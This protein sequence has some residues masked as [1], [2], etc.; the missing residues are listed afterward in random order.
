MPYKP[1][2]TKCRAWV[3]TTNN[4]DEA[5]EAHL[6]SL[7]S[8]GGA[9]YLCY[10]REVG[11]ECGTPHLQGFVYFENPR[12]FNGVRSTLCEG[13]H[14]EA[15]RG[16][17]EQSI[18]YC[19]KDGDFVELGKRPISKAGSDKAARAVELARAGDLETLESEDPG[20]FL[21]HFRT[22]GALATCSI[23][24]LSTLKNYWLWGPPGTGKTTRAALQENAYRKD[25]N[26]WWCGYKDEDWVIIEEWCPDH[27]CLASKLKVWADR[28]YFKAETK[29]GSMNIRPRG[30]IITSNYSIGE[31]FK[32]MVDVAAIHRRFTEIL[33][34]EPFVHPDDMTKY[35]PFA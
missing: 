11:S 28:Q 6:Q 7:V 30:I 27:A 10:G 16:T 4:Y 33:M 31:C 25:A 8:S 1:S 32:T 15:C 22:L 17:S 9:R 3:F 13:S 24:T 29:G 12:A 14:I 5:N 34:D 20:T 26:K 35:T 21:R 18:A 2:S 23:A 19:C